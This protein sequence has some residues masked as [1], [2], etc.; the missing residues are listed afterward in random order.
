MKKNNKKSKKISL[1]MYLARYKFGIS[2]YILVYLIAGASIV[3]QT[4]LFAKAI[5]QITLSLFREAMITLGMI[6]SSPSTTKWSAW[7][8]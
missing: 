3:L 2:M 1:S 5:E 6:G 4:I 7:T 8:L